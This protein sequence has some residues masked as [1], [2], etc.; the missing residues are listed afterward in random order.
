MISES[1]NG[2]MS[3]WD[4][5]GEGTLG[6]VMRCESMVSCLISHYRNLAKRRLK[7]QRVTAEPQKRRVLPSHI[8]LNK[9]FFYMNDGITL[10]GG[11]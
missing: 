6:C 2:L 9:T 4:K 10:C 7:G 3:E 11:K 8:G 1:Q 5:G